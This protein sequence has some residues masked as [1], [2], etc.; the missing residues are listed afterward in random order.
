ML[1]Y[2]CLSICFWDELCKFICFE[3]CVYLQVHDVF[4]FWVDLW[5]HNVRSLS[6]YW[7]N[8]RGQFG[9]F[10]ISWFY[11]NCFQWVVKS[12]S[13]HYVGYKGGGWCCHCCWRRWNSSWG[14]NCPFKKK[15]IIVGSVDVIWWIYCYLNFYIKNFPREKFLSSIYLIRKGS[16]STK[17]SFIM[18]VIKRN[19]KSILNNRKCCGKSMLE[20]MLLA[21]PCYKTHLYF[22]YIMVATRLEPRTLQTAQTF[23]TRDWP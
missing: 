23:P 8:E 20:I 3:C 12:L 17:L 14:E 5:I 4:C 18:F 22:W 6:C 10:E 13:L 15:K 1:C 7:H 16:S 19:A 9:V 2:E 21:F 11:V